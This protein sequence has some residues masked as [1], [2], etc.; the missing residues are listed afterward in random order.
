MIIGKMAM[1]GSVYADLSEKDFA[2]KIFGANVFTENISEYFDVKKLS[3]SND[4]KVEKFIDDLKADGYYVK[5]K[6]YSDFTSVLGVKKKNKMAT[7]GEVNNRSKKEMLNYLNMYFDNYSELR[8]IAV[9]EDN[10]LTRKMLNSLDDEL[11]ELAYE[12]A[13]Y[14]IKADTQYE[15][16]GG[17][18]SNEEIIKDIDFEDNTDRKH[19]RYDF[20]FTTYDKQGAEILDYDG[21]IIE[22]PSSSRMN[23][24]IEWGQNT[25]EDWES[26]EKILI[27]AFY[28]WKNKNNKMAN[29][30]GVGFKVGDFVK[31]K[32]SN[33][34]VKVIEVGNDWRSGYDTITIYNDVTNDKTT[35]VD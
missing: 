33:L 25:P 17:V 32:G 8:T 3:S 35:L 7:G 9:E 14:E 5:K 15:N 23:D 16:G 10:I 13:K 28:E 12:D 22:S 19:G 11:L 4:N 1:G 20:S 27:D 29:G 2:N 31:K 6:A 26:A 34:K 24:E 18:L 30:G 21:Y